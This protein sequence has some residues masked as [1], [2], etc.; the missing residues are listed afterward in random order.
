MG[1]R[2][3]S[4]ATD[5]RTVITSV[6]PKIGVGHTLPLYYSNERGRLSAALLTQFYCLIF[7]FVARLKIGGTHLTYSYLNQFPAP[8]PSAFSATDLDFIT[9]RVLE[10]T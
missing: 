2:D 1:W 5:E 7:D 10:L 6:M 4:R 3:I 8:P 9:P